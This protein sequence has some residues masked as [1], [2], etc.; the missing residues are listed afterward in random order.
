MS[1]LVGALAEPS[2]D[3]DAPGRRHERDSA[4]DEALLVQQDPLLGP[5]LDSPVI[6][7]PVVNN[8]TT[9]GTVTL[10]RIGAD[11]EV[12]HIAQV[13]AAIPPMLDRCVARRLDARVKEKRARMPWKARA[14]ALPVDR[15]ATRPAG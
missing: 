7:A 15:R 5:E 1:S 2:K 10:C 6:P 9:V 13:V 12:D 3:R 14:I 8:V 4:H 11:P